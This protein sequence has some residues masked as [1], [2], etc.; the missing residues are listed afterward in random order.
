MSSFEGVQVF[1]F[2]SEDS[3][4][5]KTPFL[6]F[7]DRILLHTPLPSLHHPRLTTP[8]TTHAA[9]RYEGTGRSL[10][11]KLIQ[12]LRHQSAAPA[13]EAAAAGAGAAGAGAGAGAAGGAGANARV[14]RTITLETPIRYQ[15]HRVGNMNGK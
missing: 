6:L 3:Q 1:V 14:L 5:I 9:T 10:S 2:L 11:L 12:Q 15:R 8:P 4:N 7:Y 13:A